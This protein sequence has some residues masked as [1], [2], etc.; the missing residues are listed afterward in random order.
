MDAPLS[1]YKWDITISYK[2]YNIFFDELNI[3]GPKFFFRITEKYIAVINIDGHRRGIAVYNRF[4]Q[5]HIIDF[6]DFYEGESEYRVD[7]AFTTFFTKDFQAMKVLGI[8]STEN[9]TLFLTRIDLKTLK[10][11]VFNPVKF[12]DKRFKFHV[13]FLN[14]K[15]IEMYFL[16][17]DLNELK[18]AESQ[19]KSSFE[20]FMEACLII[21]SL[22]ILVAT[23]CE[24][25]SMKRRRLFFLSI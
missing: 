18:C 15:K 20:V 13:G 1:P 19:N 21:F 25:D 2:Y 9:E 12:I 24:L 4:I 10:I 3:W 17:R 16:I 7:H 11:K 22:L 5:S 6:F 23:G 8:D 14:G